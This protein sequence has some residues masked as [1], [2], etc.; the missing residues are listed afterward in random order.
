MQAEIMYW[1]PYRNRDSDMTGVLGPYHSRDKAIVARKT[2]I[3]D[4][5]QYFE[6]EIP[7]SAPSK[8][9]AEHLAKRM[10]RNV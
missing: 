4:N 2:F 1:V 9:E 10:S 3:A 6:V 5:D 8:A 7:M